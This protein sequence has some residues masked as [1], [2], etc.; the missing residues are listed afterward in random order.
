MRR[1]PRLFL[2]AVL[3]VARAS[4]AEAAA[5]EGQVALPPGADAPMARPRYPVTATYTVGEPDPPTAIVYLEGD[6][7]TAPASAAPAADV[8]QRA[9]QF[10]PGLV[11][12]RRGSTV[13]FP[14]LDE[15]YHSVFSYSKTR[16]FDLG[17]YQR[18]ET[19][20]A[21]RFEQAGVVRLFC[22]IHEHMRG[23][24]LVLDTPHFTRTDAAGRYRLDGLPA[25]Q[26]VLKAWIDEDTV[27]EQPVVLREGATARADFPQ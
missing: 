10:A 19:P 5:V 13:R 9:Y 21:L 24:I 25:G 16:R 22:E 18:D 23:T 17:R 3:L 1:C 8:A 20:P 2:L 7:G 12:V 4:R 11:A 26:F 27:R 14:N 15:E 6:F